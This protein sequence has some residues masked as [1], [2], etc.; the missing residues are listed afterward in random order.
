[1]AINTFAATLADVISSAQKAADELD[2]YD[3]RTTEIELR[4]EQLLEV[5]PHRDGPEGEL[6]RQLSELADGYQQLWRINREMAGCNK[7]DS[8]I[9]STEE[10]L[11]YYKQRARVMEA[12][13]DEILA[14]MEAD[15]SEVHRLAY[16][17]HRTDLCALYKNV[18]T[19]SGV[20]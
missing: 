1:M 6:R 4:I 9:L 8:K 13:Q 19:L 7:G 18:L 12:E 15:Y 2:F 20:L 16:L 11:D 3:R 5:V 17:E 14:R 10:R